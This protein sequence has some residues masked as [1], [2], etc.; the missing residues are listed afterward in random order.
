MQIIPIV[1][2]AAMLVFN[3]RA[4]KTEKMQTSKKAAFDN[5]ERGRER[6]RERKREREREGID[7]Q[8]E[9]EREREGEKER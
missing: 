2:K 4:G 8:R 1:T 6:E 9:R 3:A 5:D 7:R